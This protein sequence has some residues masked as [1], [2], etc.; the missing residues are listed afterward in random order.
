MGMPQAVAQVVP[1]SHES[2]SDE[3]FEDFSEMEQEIFEDDDQTINGWKK[4]MNGQYGG[5]YTKKFTRDGMVVHCV[6]ASPHE[7]LGCLAPAYFSDDKEHLAEFL[8]DMGLS[9]SIKENQP[10]LLWL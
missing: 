10:L 1:F 7:S 6:N 5:L 3:E 2:M 4:N 9:G 8:S